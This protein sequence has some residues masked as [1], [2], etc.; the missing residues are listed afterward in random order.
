MSE[1]EAKII[2]A[3]ARNQLSISRAANDL[4]YHRNTIFYHV[5]KIRKK[6]GLDP[7]DFYDMVNL[8]PMAQE[9]T[10]DV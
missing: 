4:T 3:L 6:T 7:L 9:V 2:F 10:H 8:I 5:K 1:Q